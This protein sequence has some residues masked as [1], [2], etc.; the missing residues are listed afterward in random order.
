[1]GRLGPVERVVNKRVK[2]FFKN[3]H[4]NDHFK[5][6]VADDRMLIQ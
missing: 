3:L 6:L 5:D 4:R 2:K 1:M